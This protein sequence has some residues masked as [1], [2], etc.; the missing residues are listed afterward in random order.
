MK[1]N[2]PSKELYNFVS[3]VSKVLSSRNALSIL[4]NFLFSLEGTRLTIVACDAENTLVGSTDVT[5]AEG[6]GKFCIDAHRIADLLKE[7]PDQGITFQINDENLA[8]EIQYSNGTYNFVA[9]NGDEYPVDLDNLSMDKDEDNPKLAEFQVPAESFIKGISNTVFAVGNDDLRPQMQGVLCDIHEDDITF[10]ATDTKQLVRYIDH[11]L[12]TGQAL[13]FVIPGKPSNVIRT[14]FS[15]EGDI[16]VTVYRK[17][18]LFESAKFRFMCSLLKGRYPDYNRV[19]PTSS[20]SELRVGRDEF[21]RALRRV[22]IFCSGQG[23]IKFKIT[24]STVYMRTDDAGTC[25][26]ALESVP[27][28][29]SGNPMII[30]FNY[31]YLVDMFS[32]LESQEGIIKLSDQSRPGLIVPTDNPEGTE[33]VMLLMP[34][35]V[36]DFN[37]E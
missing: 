30:G 34:M 2:V 9:I 18:A 17:S 11:N 6:E 33:L 29:F 14:T 36:S 19:I 8:V 27:C 3:T 31:R 15:R 22:G 16:K 7:L 35:T 5:D 25:G 10:V 23:L 37:M 1:F 4:N 20:S 21:I 13:S 28:E 32:T 12:K 26:N 24:P